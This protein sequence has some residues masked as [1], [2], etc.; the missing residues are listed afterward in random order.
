MIELIFL[1]L[2]LF[3]LIMLYTFYVRK[4]NTDAEIAEQTKVAIEKGK[5]IFFRLWLIGSSLW[6]GFWFFVLFFL[7]GEHNR[8]DTVII[9]SL[10]AIIPPTFV[11]I[12]GRLISWAFKPA[13]EGR[14]PKG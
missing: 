3:V 4:G 8:D 1:L 2:L 13:L 14:L 10:V 7:I 11:Y 12:L 6:T 9:L 5:T